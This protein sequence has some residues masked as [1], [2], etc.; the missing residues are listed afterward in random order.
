MRR[1]DQ[2]ENTRGT[3]QSHSRHRLRPLRGATIGIGCA[4]GGAGVGHLVAGLVDPASSPV[5]AVGSKIIDATPTPVK[6]WA[7]ATFGSSD[8]IVLLSSVALTTAL[9]AAVAGIVATRHRRAGVAALALL[10]ALAT[11]AAVTRPAAGS[12][13]IVPGLVTTLV[14][15]GS[16]LLL[17]RPA[18]GRGRPESTDDRDGPATRVPTGVG[19]TRRHVLLGAGGLAVA[20]TAA[21]VLGQSLATRAAAIRRALPGARHPLPAL[22]T[23]LESTVPGVTAL[24]T[25]RSDFYR[26]DTALVVPQVDVDGWRLRI[27]GDV[28]APFELTY[29]DLLAMPLVERDITLTCVSNEVGGTYA[30][31]ARWLGVDVAELLQRAGVADGVDQILSTSTDGYT[32]STPLQA[33]TDARGAMIAVGMNGETLDATHGFPA[34]LITPGLYGYVGATKWLTTLTATT[35]AAAPA[36]WTRRGWAAQAPIKTMTR[37]DTPAPLSSSAPGRLAVAGVAWAQRRGIDRVEVRIDDGPW[38]NAVLG[39]EVDIDYWRQW[40]LPW[41]ATP[42]Q[43]TLTARAVDGTGAPQVTASAKP[44][45]DGASG[46]HSI[47]VV[48]A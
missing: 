10:V 1:S 6:E 5:L 16:M 4:V 39:P 46:L 18:R 35:F 30:G 7:V 20:G 23:G 48:V 37:I 3:T 27:D 12:L 40:Y 25:P 11:L 14:G 32:A 2:L 36:Y 29:D 21:G 45:P 41:D 19:T 15:V 17:T 43:H 47:V 34:R 26:V 42:G 44:F 9:L 33:L 13:S 28:Q 8:K 31:G 24:R 38:Q 22:P